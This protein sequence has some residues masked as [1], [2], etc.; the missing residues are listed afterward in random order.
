[1]FKLELPEAINARLD[2]L[3]ALTGHSKEFHARE[4]I[5]QYLD[6]VDDLEVAEQVRRRIHSGEERTSLLSDVEGET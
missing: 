1:M 4:A 5:A 2:R 3:A 6:D